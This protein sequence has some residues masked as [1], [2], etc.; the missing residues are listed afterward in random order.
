MKGKLQL[1]LLVGLCV[2]VNSFTTKGGETFRKEERDF[3]RTNQTSSVNVLDPSHVNKSED[4]LPAG[5]SISDIT[6]INCNFGFNLYRKMADKHDNNVFFSPLSVY[7]A[8]ASLML[9]TKGITHEQL[10]LGLNLNTF[11]INENPYLLPTLLKI[12]KGNITKNEE[13]VLELGSFSFIHEL[14]P[15]KETFLKLTSEY[16]D[17][18]YQMVDFQNSTHA[19]NIINHYVSKKTQG[20]IPQLYDDVDPQT[21][22]VLIDYILFKG[23]SSSILLLVCVFLISGIM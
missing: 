13:F 21:K 4:Q 7:F 23:K 15:I 6:E 18:Q 14:F 20:K 12:I 2:D 8:L 16:F 9:G 22:L 19:K 17:L 10:L 11:N 5:L 3:P 1:L